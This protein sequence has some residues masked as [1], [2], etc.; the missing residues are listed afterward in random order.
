VTTTAVVEY[1]VVWPSHSQVPPDILRLLEPHEWLY[2]YVVMPDSS[3]VL[4][5]AEGSDFGSKYRCSASLWQIDAATGARVRIAGGVMPTLSPDGRKLAYAQLRP[6]SERNPSQCGLD[7]IAVR[8]IATGLTTKPNLHS[9]DDDRIA[10]FSLVWSPD[11]TR[12]RFYFGYEHSDRVTPPFVYDLAGNSAELVTIEPSVAEE[13]SANFAP[14]VRPRKWDISIGTWLLD[15][16]LAV[17]VSC[18]MGCPDLPRDQQPGWYRVDADYVLRS[19]NGRVVEPEFLADLER[20][21][22]LTYC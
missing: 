4:G 19:L 22:G 18:G 11:S 2:G 6:P 10:A 8:D 7:D 3:I 12:L 15:R 9:D 16:T 21:L 1:R 5:T 20:C 17:L 13:L 14:T